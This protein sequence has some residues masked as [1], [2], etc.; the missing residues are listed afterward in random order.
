MRIL[1]IGESG[2]LARAL[3]RL[4]RV[5]CVG[6]AMFD[7]ADATPKT[8]EAL[9]RMHG[10]EAVINAAAYTA[11]DQAESEPGAA[12]AL[13]RDGP[14]ALAH[15][16]AAVDIGL[17]QVST[18]YVFDG[19]KSTP[20]FETDVKAPQSVYGASK[21]A[22]EDGVLTSGARAAVLRTSWVYAAEG[23]NFV[24]TMLHLAQTR[25]EIGVVADQSGRPTWAADLAVTCTKVARLLAAKERIAEGVF[26]Y[27]GAGDATWA[28]FAEAIFEKA[29][30]HGWPSARVKRIATA[31]YPTPAKRPA[32]SRLDTGKIEV[33]LDLRPRPWREA[34]D[35]C[36]REIAPP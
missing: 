21:S 8:A 20:Y 9:I 1:V 10:A 13:N 15:A 23:A 5:V 36:L 12:Y 28:D 34:L 32:N 14:A 22:G 33:D 16:C 2:Q 7:L 24:R 31:D 26:H 18:D 19:L 17:V 35:L 11:V 3:S 4:D 6:R 27:A 30:A 29:R 25:E